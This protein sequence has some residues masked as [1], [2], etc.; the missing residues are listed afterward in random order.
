[1]SLYEKIKMRQNNVKQTDKDQNL[2]Q[3]IQ[4]IRSDLLSQVQTTQW[5]EDEMEKLRLNVEELLEQ[6][7]IDEEKF[8]PIDEKRNLVIQ[9]V[10]DIVGLGP[11]QPLLDD[12]EVSEIMVNGPDQIFVERSG[13]IQLSS[14]HFINDSHIMNVIERIIS[15]I[16]RRVDE[17]SPMVDARLKDG[18]RFNA[19]IPPLAL[20]GPTV[21][22]RKFKKDSLSV[23]DLISFK[24]LSKEMATFLQDA[25]KGHFNI[26]VAGG[27][28]SGKTTLL[29]ILSSF[30]PSDERIV[31]IEDAAELKLMQP[32]VVSLETRPP[33]I[34]GKGEVTIRDL[35]KNSLR[36]RPDRI[37]VG[38]V[39]SGEALDM[40]QAMNTGHDGSLS[41]IHAN[42]PRDVISRLET[43]MLMS[44][45]DLPLKA[46]REQIASAVDLIVQQ[47]RFSD[48]SRR[49]TNI[50]KVEGIESGLVVLQ[51]LFLFEEVPSLGSEKITGR[52]KKVGALPKLK[53]DGWE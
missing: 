31:T 44:G 21:T 15:P 43:L 25:V 14:Q 33:N 23:Q 39:R 7:L 49:I 52:F 35:L 17:S 20:N 1:M 40:L 22:I 9:V 2:S 27:T 4:K 11:I 16:G 18:S 3:M 53:G 24:A 48:G 28:G 8:L 6:Y 47:R 50:A 19:I 38:E 13:K 29:N 46:L 10:Q 42:T 37:I 41:T 30:I 32:H 34:E 51:D 36:M 12:E 45:Y 5:S 26:L